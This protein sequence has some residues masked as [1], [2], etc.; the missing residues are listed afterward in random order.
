MKRLIY[1]TLMEWKNDPHRKPLILRGARQ[2]GKTY[3]IREFGQTFPNFVEINFEREPK[4]KTIF[5]KNFDPKRIIRDISLLLE[6]NIIPGETLLFFD[7]IQEA[8][9]AI[10]ALRYFYEEIPKLHVIAAGSLLEFSLHNIGMPVGRVTFLSMYPMSLIEFIH[11]CGLEK[12]KGC[13]L[14]QNPASALSEIVHQQLLEIT[15]IYMAIGGMPEAVKKWVETRD[16][17]TCLNIHNAIIE[18][19]KQDFHKYATKFQIKPID[20]LFE[21]IPLMLGQ[22]FKYA[23]IPGEYRKRELAPCIDLLEKA[24]IIH[25]VYHSSAQG[26][27][28][29]AQFNPNNFKIIFVDVAIAQA[30][31]GLDLK[32]WFLNPTET[33]INQGTITESFIGQEILAYSEAYRKT[34]LYYWQREK[35]SSN[36]EIDYLIQHK[37]KVIPI[38]VKSGKGTKLK[39]LQIFLQ[40][41]KNSPYG[42]RFSTHNFSIQ[43]WLHSYPLYAAA[44]LFDNA[45]NF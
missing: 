19:Y 27:P 5:D 30:I 35:R 36:A 37:N 7:E 22:K 10:T 41:H 38:E 17:K 18:A 8:P 43:D 15:A 28:I 44:N 4:F 6:Q 20:L 9:K 14:Q 39:S 3:I 11:A 31:L 34:Q 45:K 12:M 33:L 16:I 1:Q 23:H 25:R 21:H 32:N 24:H 13:V 29:A 26:I 2:V 40:S 42:I